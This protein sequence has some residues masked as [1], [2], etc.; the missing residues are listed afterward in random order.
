[1]KFL[2][3]ESVREGVL[4]QKGKKVLAF[5]APR[6]PRGEM[7]V[8]YTGAERKA[9]FTRQMLDAALNAPAGEMMSTADISAFVRQAAVDIAV[10]AFEY[11]T[12]YQHIYDI[13]KNADFPRHVNVRDF[14]GMVAAFG[15]VEE[16]ESVPL[17]GFKVGKV[18]SVDF[19]TYAAGYSISHDWVQ[20]NEFWKVPQANKALG[21]A[22]NAI[23][24][25]IHLYPII[26]HSYTGA[27]K[28]SAVTTGA[29]ALENVYLSLREGIKGALKRKAS[30]GY[31]VRPTVALCNSATAMD[32]EA[33]VK[34]LMQK[35]TQLG[36]L[37]QI[38]TVVAY[39]GWEGEVNSVVYSF[40][41]PK[42]NE[43]FLIAPK[44]TFKS[45]VKEDLTTLKQR[46][47]VLTLSE[48]DVAQAFTV[49]PVAG[50]ANAVQKVLIK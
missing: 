30:N 19:K 26:S 39:D 3:R 43:V 48:M 27:A 13:I 49:A 47:N 21:V 34:G 17:A 10:G 45:L 42:D 32:V 8:V 28:T 20:F 23:N 4:Q 36:E 31:R 25:H 33:A 6:M 14:I 5:A 40:D 11:P 16:G 37:G 1:M 22:H 2:T 9:L 41:A 7:T 15:I 44:A 50:V 12:V 24:D 35:G 38:K 29:T 46:G 18:Q